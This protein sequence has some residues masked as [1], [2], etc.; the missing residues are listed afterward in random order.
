MI[1]SVIRLD[2]RNRW[3]SD[4]ATR[5]DQCHWK[6]RRSP[7]A[8]L[9]QSPVAAYLSRLHKLPQAKITNM[10][11]ALVS[12]SA[13]IVPMAIPRSSW[14]TIPNRIAVPAAAIKAKVGITSR[15]MPPQ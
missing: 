8:P 10:K 15:P 13:R 5:L 3:T 2:W 7:R 14:A 1:V 4:T 12:A 11:P 9:S 6:R